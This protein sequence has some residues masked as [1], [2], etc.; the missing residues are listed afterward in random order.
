MP[1]Y[2]CCFCGKTNTK[3]EDIYQSSG[4]LGLGETK[5]GEKE[6]LDDTV[7]FYR[8]VSCGRFYC[9][10]HYELLCNKTRKEKGWLTNKVIKYDECPKCGFN[11][12]KKIC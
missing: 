10:D 8:C 2:E 3:I 4:F 9:K 5:I 1:K 12:V 11:E 6:I 7:S